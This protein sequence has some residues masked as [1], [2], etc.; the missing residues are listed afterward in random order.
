MRFRLVLALAFLLMAPALAGSVEFSVVPGRAVLKDVDAGGQV[1]DTA[2]DSDTGKLHLSLEG[3]APHHYRIERPPFDARDLT[4]WADPQGN[5]HYQD[6]THQPLL[7]SSTVFS[8]SRTLVLNVQPDDARIYTDA[9]LALDGAQGDVIEVA[10]MRKIVSPLPRQDAAV[11]VPR[12]YHPGPIYLVHD[13]Y[14]TR[15]VVFQP[16][17]L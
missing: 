2:A 12:A 3:S 1:L 7:N 6:G 9:A 10:G 13:G 17:E 14:Q 4:V 8:L 5:W 11:V 15:M 16:G